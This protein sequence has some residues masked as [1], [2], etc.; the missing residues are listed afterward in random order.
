MFE[1]L[2]LCN[3]GYQPKKGTKIVTKGRTVAFCVYGCRLELRLN[4]KLIHVASVCAWNVTNLYFIGLNV[5]LWIGGINLNFSFH[6]F[7]P[8]FSLSLTLC[9]CQAG[10][11]SFFASTISWTQNFFYSFFLYCLNRLSTSAQFIHQ[12]ELITYP[13]DW[14][15]MITTVLMMTMMMPKKKSV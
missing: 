9:L 4:F 8:F 7:A 11:S 3:R 15:M 5:L 1:I 12:I 2:P 13:K 14:N 10:S 6:S